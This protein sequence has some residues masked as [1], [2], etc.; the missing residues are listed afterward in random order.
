LK[1]F[2]QN[3]PILVDCAPQ[4]ELT[5]LDGYNDFV[6]MP[7]IARVWLPMTQAPRNGRPKFYNP[8]PDCFLRNVDAALQKK[9]LDFTKTQVEPAIKPNSMRDNFRWKTV[10]FIAD[11]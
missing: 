10:M 4:P 8:P 11:Q 7:D 5:A 9:L 2:I 1:N 6:E 3:Q